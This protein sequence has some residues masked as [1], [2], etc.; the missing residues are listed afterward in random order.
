LH[1][2]SRS[3]SCC[4]QGWGLVCAS[5]SFLPSPLSF[6]SLSLGREISRGVTCQGSLGKVFQ[7]VSCL[8]SSAW[9]GHLARCFCWRSAMSSWG[10][11]LATDSFGA[12]DV[13]R[14]WAFLS[15]WVFPW[16]RSL[17]CRA[18]SLSSEQGNRK[19]CCLG[20]R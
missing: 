14:W 6:L 18:S 19:C 12:D 4:A 5:L 2:R 8:F 10:R 9:G 7:T 20:A 13:R 17:P 16:W 15:L 1:G 3:L 11:R